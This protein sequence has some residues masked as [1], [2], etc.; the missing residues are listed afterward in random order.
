MQYLYLK[1]Q[2]HISYFI[3]KYGAA[4]SELEF[5]F[6]ALF[7]GSCES[8]LLVS[9]KLTLQQV[10]RYRPA[11]HCDERFIFSRACVVYR[12]GEH[13]LARTA[14]SRDQDRRIASRRD[15]SLL[16]G[17]H[18]LLAGSYYIINGVLYLACIEI[19][20]EF[21]SFFNIPEGNNYSVYF[22]AG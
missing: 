20:H 3:Q 22:L 1:V 21:L 10:L 14:L 9:E 5:T 12:L 4:V 7:T 11:V 17:Y 15:Q 18:Y 13:L 6:L 16:L 19:I 2:R 8:A